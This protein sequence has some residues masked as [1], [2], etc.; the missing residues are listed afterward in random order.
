MA[1]GIILI[2]TG[3]YSLVQGIAIESTV[4]IGLVGGGVLLIFSTD[5][6]IDLLL[7]FFKSKTKNRE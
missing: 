4:L 3:C 6:A 1:I 5:R 7:G 2:A